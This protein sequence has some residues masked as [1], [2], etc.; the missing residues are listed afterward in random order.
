MRSLEG[1]SFADLEVEDELF[2]SL[3]LTLLGLEV[4]C[5]KSQREVIFC[6]VTRLLSRKIQPGDKR[7]NRKPPSHNRAKYVCARTGQIYFA[8]R[9]TVMK[10][11]ELSKQDHQK[12]MLLFPENSEVQHLITTTERD[13]CSG[14]CL[15]AWPH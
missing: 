8:L 9:R 3:R 2:V 11:F 6:N 1:L 13:P 15:L 5:R 12:V 7:R 10:A 4:M 14:R